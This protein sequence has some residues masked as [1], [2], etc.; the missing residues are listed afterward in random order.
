MLFIITG[1]SGTGK[2][3]LVPELKNLLP[4]NYSILDFDELGRPYDNTDVWKDEHLRKHV[5]NCNA[6][7]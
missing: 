5:F 4:Q 3:S 6:K 7:S 1:A 2:S